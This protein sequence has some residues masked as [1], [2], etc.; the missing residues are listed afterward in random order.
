MNI[1]V[2]TSA[3]YAMADG[4]DFNNQAAL[5][6][7]AK[8]LQEADLLVTSSYALAETISLLHARAGTSV[9]RAFVETVLSAIEIDWVDQETHDAALSMMLETE[10]KSGPSLTD[11]ANL[12]AMRRLRINTIF[13]YDKHYNQPGITVLGG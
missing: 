5:Q 2:D 13:A 4:S 6:A 11:C 1:L 9:V 10:G 7:W 3:M 8:L 12:E